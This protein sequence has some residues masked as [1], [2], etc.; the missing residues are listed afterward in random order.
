M[1]STKKILTSSL[2]FRTN[3]VLSFPLLFFMSAARDFA[4]EPSIIWLLSVFLCLIFIEFK[5]FKRLFPVSFAFC[6]K[7]IYISH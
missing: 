4:L 5:R 3:A 7:L 2:A 6:S 1:P